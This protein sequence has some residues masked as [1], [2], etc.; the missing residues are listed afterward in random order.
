MGD[1]VIVQI[2]SAQREISLMWRTS[3]PATLNIIIC[4]ANISSDSVLLL[5]FFF[6]FRIK[7][8]LANEIYRFHSHGNWCRR[9]Q[10]IFLIAFAI[11][12]LWGDKARLVAIADIKEFILRCCVNAL[13]DEN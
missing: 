5:Y 8:F 4:E 6:L 2:H 10:P 3:P 7:T 1:V 12:I 9:R 13:E 11:A